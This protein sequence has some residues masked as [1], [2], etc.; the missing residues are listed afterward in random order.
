MTI[1]DIIQEHQDFIIK[2]IKFKLSGYPL[3]SQDEVYGEVVKALER[4]LESKR[5][6]LKYGLPSMQR[7]I[8]KTIDS[9][10][11]DYFRRLKRKPKTLSHREA[12]HLRRLESMMTEAEIIEAFEKTGLNLKKI[13]YPQIFTLRLM[14]KTRKEIAEIWGISEDQVRGRLGRTKKR[15]QKNPRLI[16]SLEK[17]LEKEEKFW[18]EPG[19]SKKCRKKKF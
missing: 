15:L 4:A 9:K 6:I 7:Y 11:I 19:K 5:L 2:I 10:C 1:F 18:L 16:R 13:D 17:I 3:S 14:R 8:R 12:R